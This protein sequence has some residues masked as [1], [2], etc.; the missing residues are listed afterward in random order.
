M[1]HSNCSSLFPCNYYRSIHR[2]EL[3]PIYSKLSYCNNAIF[4]TH[5]Y[6]LSKS[7]INT[8][9][10]EHS[11]IVIM[12]VHHT[13]IRFKDDYITYYYYELNQTHDE[14]LWKNA[15]MQWPGLQGSGDDGQ[16]V[17]VMIGT[18]YTEFRKYLNLF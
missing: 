1:T 9:R 3:H 8:E 14:M 6:K 2:G 4:F 16:W 10:V 11:K 15:V 13:M 17:A 5:Q 18:I 12:A 7:T